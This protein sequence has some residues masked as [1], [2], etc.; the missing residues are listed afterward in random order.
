M[1]IQSHNNF[2]SSKFS[3]TL[4]LHL[5]F[6]SVIQAAMEILLF[7]SKYYRT[8]NDQLFVSSPSDSKILRVKEICG[9]RLIR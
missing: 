8:H 2:T 7:S 5:I 6:K 3:H 9:A 4:D 1:T